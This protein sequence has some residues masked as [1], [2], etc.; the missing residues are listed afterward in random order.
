MYPLTRPFYPT[1][2]HDSTWWCSKKIQPQNNE[3]KSILFKFGKLAFFNENARFAKSALRS[4]LHTATRWAG[5]PRDF[6]A[7][8]ASLP[9]ITRRR[10]KRLFLISDAFLITMM[11]CRDDFCYNNFFSL[12]HA[13][14]QSRC[15]SLTSDVCAITESHR[16]RHSCSTSGWKVFANTVMI[17]LGMAVCYRC[18]RQLAVCCSAIHCRH[19]TNR[20]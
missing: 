9:R 12:A 19:A 18:L 11:S 16:L 2:P 13:R 20:K 3:Q 6:F 8:T 14:R 10:L 4:G 5:Q 15:L 17:M 7:R 1:P